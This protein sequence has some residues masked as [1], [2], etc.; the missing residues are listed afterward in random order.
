MLLFWLNIF[1]N[2]YFLEL[3]FCGFNGFEYLLLFR[4]GEYNN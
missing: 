3:K 4:F 2:S 1:Y